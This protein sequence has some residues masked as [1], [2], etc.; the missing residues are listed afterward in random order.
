MTDMKFKSTILS[1][2]LIA[3]AS[4]AVYEIVFFLTIEKK[5]QTY[6]LINIGI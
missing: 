3:V 1:Y 2:K 5:I 6:Q 4:S